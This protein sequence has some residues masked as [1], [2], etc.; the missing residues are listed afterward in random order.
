LTQTAV[1][2]QTT[3]NTATWTAYN[4][5]PQDVFESVDTATVNV[6]PPSIALTKT[7]GTDSSVCANTD[8]IDVVAG[9]AVTYCFEVTNT[10]LTT[11][12]RH[13]LE[14][15]HLGMIL[16][17]LSFSLTP[18]ASVFLT[19][20]AVITQTTVNTATWTAYNPGPSDVVEDSD[21]ATV[22][23]VPPSIALT[24]TVGTDASVCANTR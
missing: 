17:G 22:N 1:I 4:P 7:V 10:G 15:S 3:V 13:D 19:Q 24:K 20:T 21:S 2:T 5:G 23:V 16:D 12:T 11:F 14:D 9:T 18:G 8:E 6:V